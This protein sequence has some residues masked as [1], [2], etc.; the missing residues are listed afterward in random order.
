MKRILIALFLISI[1][2]LTMAGE[3]EQL[4]CKGL[5]Q[6]T[7]RDTIN[8][9][10]GDITHDEMRENVELFQHFNCASVLANLADQI[11]QESDRKLSECKQI[12]KKLKKLKS[13][14]E[15]GL[16]RPD[17][18]RRFDDLDEYQLQADKFNLKNCRNILDKNELIF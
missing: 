13:E 6:I 18:G 11:K 8:F 15:L 14:L 2:G 3:A 7:L 12:N 17:T 10:N 1:S 4:I 16:L 9:R 5:D